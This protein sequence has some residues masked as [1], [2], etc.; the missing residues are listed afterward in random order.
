M[1]SC[2]PTTSHPHSVFDSLAPS[3][4]G[5]MSKG[6]QLQTW[7]AVRRGGTG[8][9]CQ[10]G[11]PPGAML[12]PNLPCFEAAGDPPRRQESSEALLPLLQL[13]PPSRSRQGAGRVCP[14][15]QGA[16]P[17]V[18]I[19]KITGPL[20]GR[21]LRRALFRGSNLGVGVTLLLS[22]LRNSNLVLSQS[23]QQKAT[24]ATN[25]WVIFLFGQ[26]IQEPLA[27]SWPA[28][29]LLGFA[30]SR[31]PPPLLSYHINVFAS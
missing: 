4:T 9:H 16:S 15:T 19:S 13:P 1:R 25:G 29:R 21:L 28:E 14:L 27:G 26:K 31:Q 22:W 7:Q 6:G 30:P 23:S 17:Q 8:H 5:Q 20:S 18:S 12:P 3:L 24:K 2:S 11:Y 10:C